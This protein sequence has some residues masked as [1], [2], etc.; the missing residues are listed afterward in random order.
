MTYN[1][2]YRRTGLIG[3]K[4]GMTSIF[5]ELNQQIPVTL[6]KID[7]NQVSGDK[8]GYLQLSSTDTDKLSKPLSKHFQSLNIHPKKHSKEFKVSNESKIQIGTEL[9]AAHFVPGQSQGS[10]GA[11]QDPGRVFPGK[12][13]A[14]RMGGETTTVQNLK[15][16]R[17]DTQNNT[18][19]V[20]GSI[21]GRDNGTIY[22]KD[23][24]KKL[25]IDGQNKFK[26]LGSQPEHTSKALP[27]GVDT[28]PFPAATQEMAASYPHILQAPA[29]P[30]KD[31]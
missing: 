30:K 12:K 1:P 27:W 9:S 22:I 17:I 21:P 20:K 26:K 16:V 29:A 5:N 23:A 24:I 11:N 8:D 6:I 4:Q 2:L 7:R 13:M 31:D 25:V 18:I 14:G 28:L 19:L 3:I 15:I 10:T